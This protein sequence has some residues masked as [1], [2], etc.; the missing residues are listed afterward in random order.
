MLLAL[1]KGIEYGCLGLLV[2]WIGTRAWG[3]VLAHVLVG[4]AVGIVFGGTI[5]ALTV[6]A[7]PSPV[8]TADLVSQG[9]N[10][11]LFPLGCALVL[12]SA[13]ALGSRMPSRDAP[14]DPS[15]PGEPQEACAG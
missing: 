6:G 12:F 5:L 4:L 9:L 11:L 14:A 13:G 10:E 7:A 3:G 8:P 15:K 1:I 2:G